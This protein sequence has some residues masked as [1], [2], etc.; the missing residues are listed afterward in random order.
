MITDVFTTG[1][2][3]LDEYIKEQNQSPHS[4]WRPEWLYAKDM[5]L[6]VHDGLCFKKRV[7]VIANVKVYR[8]GKGIFTDLLNHA[9]RTTQFAGVMVESVLN[10]RLADY[11]SRNGWNPTELNPWAG[12][13]NWYK[14]RE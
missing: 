1:K 10:M 13:T 12:I 11:L 7:L 8:K 14:W 9:L 3:A 6:Y 2:E 5:E 4:W